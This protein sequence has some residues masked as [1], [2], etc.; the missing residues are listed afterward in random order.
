MFRLA[1]PVLLAAIAAAAVLSAR[2]RS[3]GRPPSGAG[4][5]VDTTARDVPTT[6]PPPA[7]APPPSSAAMATTADR[8]TASSVDLDRAID[9]W[10]AA[11]LLTSEQAAAIRRHEEGLPAE[12]PAVPAT[13]RR[14]PPIAEALGYLGGILAIVGVAVFIGGFWDDL[15]AGTRV[16]ITA[17]AAAA[18]AIGGLAVPARREPALRRLRGFIWTLAAVAAAIAGGVV[19]H[20]VFDATSERATVVGGAVAAFIVSAALWAW[21]TRPAQQFTTLVALIVG[22]AVATGFFDGERLGGVATPLVGAALVVLGVRRVTPSPPVTFAVGVAG[23][24]W[25]PMA[26]VEDARGT[27]LLV[28]LACG[29][30][31]LALTQVRA[32]RLTVGERVAAAVIAGLLVLQTAPQA[33]VHFSD[34]AGVATGAVM[35]GAGALLVW[36]GARRMAGN[37]VTLEVIGGLLLV[38][39]AAI[40]GRQSEAGATV[41]GLLTAVALLALGMLPGRVLLSV[42]GSLGLLVNVPWAIAHFFPGENRAPLLIAVAGLVLV[43][44]AVVL[45]RMG[46]RFRTELRS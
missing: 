41:F 23:F 45:T 24:T 7:P 15:A 43:G 42:F 19:T 44:V 5:I 8:R 35:W 12:S 25:G 31:A 29:V 4:R 16:G 27:G 10:V 38:G 26:L 40:V 11:H 22:V 28:T 3:A 20:D 34:E 1:V 13:R 21:R 46:G 14:V 17:G 36:I 33:I 18:F 9:R 6:T 32:L 30:A 37:P 2:S 39:G